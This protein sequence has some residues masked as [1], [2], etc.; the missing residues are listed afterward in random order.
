MCTTVLLMGCE[1]EKIEPPS[2]TATATPAVYRTLPDSWPSDFPVAP[3]ATLV[4][5]RVFEDGE[6]TAKFTTPA[7]LDEVIAF[8]DNAFGAE[9]WLGYSIRNRDDV[10]WPVFN[11][12]VGKGAAV[13]AKP[14]TPGPGTNLDMNITIERR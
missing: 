8:Y 1:A 3:G 6:I 4:E 5:A 11:N 13:S 7:S 9:P 10:V 14:A 12:D 2:V